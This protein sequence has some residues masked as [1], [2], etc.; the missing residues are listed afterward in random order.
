MIAMLAFVA[1]SLTSA[2]AQAKPQLKTQRRLAAAVDKAVNEGRDAVLPPHISNLLGISPDQHE[3]PVKQFV[4]MGPPVKGF[5]VSASNH[6]QI[7]VFVEDR[8]KK[9]STFYLFSP[10][11]AVRKVLSVREGVGYDRVPSAE[12][13][14]SFESEKQFWLDRLAPAKP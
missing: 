12:D 6:D 1:F 11:G 7:V 10:R 8:S 5:E 4:I 3:V 9:E 14:K 2:D 13:K